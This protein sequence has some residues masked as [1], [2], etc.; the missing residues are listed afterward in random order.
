MK[1]IFTFFIGCLFIFFASISMASNAKTSMNGQWVC[2]TNAS[3]A[4]NDVDKKADKK[5]AN[6]QGSAAEAFA[7]AAKHCRDCT[8]ITCEF[9]NK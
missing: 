5:M 1:G 8:K 6:N 9:K 4:S 2:T 7:F 3:S